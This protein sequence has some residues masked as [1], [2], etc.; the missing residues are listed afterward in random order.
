MVREQHDQPVF[1]AG[2]DVLSGLPAV[3]RM[4]LGQAVGQPAGLLPVQA[5]VRPAGQAVGIQRDEP[6]GR[7][8]VHV[9]SRAVEPV[10]LGETVPGRLGTRPEVRGH[11]VPPGDR[12]AAPM[13]GTARF[14]PVMNTSGLTVN[15]SSALSLSKPSGSPSGFRLSVSAAAR[16]AVAVPTPWLSASWLP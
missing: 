1:L 2:T 5:A 12:P 16:P 10:L 9:V 14:G 11:E 7:G 3:G 4:D 13:A 15:S 8:V 6:H